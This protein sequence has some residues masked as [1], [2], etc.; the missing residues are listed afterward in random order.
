[1]FLFA[2]LDKT[3]HQTRS[4]AS[5]GAKPTPGFSAISVKNSLYLPIAE[6]RKSE[7]ISGR[8]H[9]AL[10]AFSANLSC[11]CTAAIM[12]NLVG[13]VRLSDVGVRVL[14]EASHASN[15]SVR[16]SKSKSSLCFC[17]ENGTSENSSEGQL[18]DT[19]GQMSY[20]VLPIN[21]LP[22]HPTS[23]CFILKV[24]VVFS[25]QHV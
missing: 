14:S 24:H 25:V 22:S 18:K 11:L 2:D 19:P 21:A 23:E 8:R 12:S 17:N 3:T 13:V 7:R 20:Q 15:T 9:S 10:C 5:V 4:I 16:P 1:M 6:V